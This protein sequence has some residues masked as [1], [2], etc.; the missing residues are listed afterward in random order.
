MLDRL[1]VAS[2]LSKGVTR[3]EKLDLYEVRL[4]AVLSLG[5]ARPPAAATN[6]SLSFSMS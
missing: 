5:C 4:E 6:D 3:G 1:F 2:V